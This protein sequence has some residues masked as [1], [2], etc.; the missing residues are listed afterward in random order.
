MHYRL[1]T[2]APAPDEGAEKVHKQAAKFPLA[3]EEGG[4]V[5]SPARIHA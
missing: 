5:L 1:P 3:G 2:P 4:S